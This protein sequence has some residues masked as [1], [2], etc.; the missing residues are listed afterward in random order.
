MQCQIIYITDSN[1][2]ATTTMQEEQQALETTFTVAKPCN[3]NVPRCTGVQKEF[4]PYTYSVKEVAVRQWM[5]LYVGV[6]IK[7]KM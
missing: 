6:D 5:H 3:Y 7:H 4:S 2:V 1:L